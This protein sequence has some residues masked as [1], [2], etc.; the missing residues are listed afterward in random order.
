MGLNATNNVLEKTNIN[1]GELNLI[2]FSTSTP[3]YISP[4]N[5]LKF[6]NEIRAGQRT[7][8]YDLNANCAGMLV[9]LEQ[10]SRF[11]RDNPRIKYALIV[12]LD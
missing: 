3:E 2:V 5:A 6:Y 11:M 8:V 12:G 9:A 10:V 1:P 4:T 7:D